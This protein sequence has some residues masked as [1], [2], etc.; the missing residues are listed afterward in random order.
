MSEH[1][2]LPAISIHDLTHRYDATE[3][4]KGVTF[5]VRRGEMFSLLGPNGSGKTTLLRILMTLIRPTGGSA[6]VCGCDVTADPAGVRRRLGVTFQSPSLDRKLTV[7]ENLT[8]HGHLH[9]LS[10]ADLRRRID[11]V[12][13]VMDLH[14]RERD[15]V[16]TLSGGLAR[17]AEIAKSLLH[18]PDVLLMDEPSTGLDPI[19]RRNVLDCLRRL[20]RDCGMTCILST[21]LMD[22]AES[23]DRVAIL[24]R[25]RLVALDTPAALKACVGGDVLT[26]FSDHPESLEAILRETFGVEARRVGRTLRVEHPK[27]HELAANLGS[28]Y[29]DR[30]AQ[31]TIS[32]PSLDDVFI[33]I[34][35]HRMENANEES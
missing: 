35:G 21:H 23:C 24:D 4:L 22:E 14:D 2:N 3:V 27:A 31:I 12:L 8:H 34:T 16:E 30:I 1:N 10:G 25:G 11:E 29:G 28:S 5:E 18:D 9:G 26:I 33:H 32:R 19:S 15:R 17:R 7:R 13:D 20:R 6:A